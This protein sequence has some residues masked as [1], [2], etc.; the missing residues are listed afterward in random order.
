MYTNHPFIQYT[1][2]SILGGV[3]YGNTTNNRFPHFYTSSMYT[4]HPFVQYTINSILICKWNI[5]TQFGESFF[6][7]KILFFPKKSILETQ[8]FRENK[9]FQHNLELNKSF[10]HNLELKKSFQHNLEL[11]KSFQHNLELKKSN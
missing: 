3:M 10:Q 1:I 11:N 9:S 6:S 7:T 2:N 5:F 8:R 4:N